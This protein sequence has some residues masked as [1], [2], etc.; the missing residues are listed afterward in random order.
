MR[1]YSFLN[2]LLLKRL[3]ECCL[4]FHQTSLFTSAR[5]LRKIRN[6]LKLSSFWRQIFKWNIILHRLPQMG[7]WSPWKPLRFKFCYFWKHFQNKLLKISQNFSLTKP[8]QDR[9]QNAQNIFC[10]AIKSV[11]LTRGTKT[12]VA[13][14]HCHPEVFCASRKFLRVTLEIAPGSFW[15]VWKV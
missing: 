14:W 4:S 1:K 6:I 12:I 8:M 15:M 10:N 7:I 13:S 3:S 5:P 9:L 11:P 2:L